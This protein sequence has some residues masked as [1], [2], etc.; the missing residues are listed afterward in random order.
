MHSVL[1]LLT[2][3]VKDNMLLGRGC[4]LLCHRQGVSLCWTGTIAGHAAAICDGQHA[5]SGTGKCCAGAAP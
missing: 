4:L 2:S 5:V 3:S 1:L